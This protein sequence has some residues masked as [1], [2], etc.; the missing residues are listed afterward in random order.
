MD[1]KVFRI[2][3]KV[4]SNRLTDVIDVKI[5]YNYFWQREC[6]SECCHVY[7]FVLCRT[8][9]FGWLFITSVC[10][11]DIVA[12]LTVL[13]TPITLSSTVQPASYHSAACG[14]YSRGL[15]GAILQ[16]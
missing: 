13:V 10:I 6:F 1:M 3:E 7:I 8:E 5:W 14:A 9:L 12:R 16:F 15:S 2:L 11:T 4:E